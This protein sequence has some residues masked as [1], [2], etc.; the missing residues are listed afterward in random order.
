MKPG[1]LLE[2]CVYWTKLTESPIRW[3]LFART[4]RDLFSESPFHSRAEDRMAAQEE[5]EATMR[6]LGVSKLRTHR[7]ALPS[8]WACTP[9]PRKPGHIWKRT[10][11]VVVVACRRDYE[12][13][14]VKGFVCA[15]LRTGLIIFCTSQQDITESSL[16]S[17]ACC[18]EH[19]KWHQTSEWFSPSAAHRL[20]SIH[21]SV[22]GH[23]SPP[24]RPPAGKETII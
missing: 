3:M 9:N 5:R 7:F 11:N 15:S 23:P 2:L 22:Q 13:W 1:L 18:W 12:V 8:R 20:R 10:R 17:E 19:R 14:V 4:H 6:R 24:L 21:C 16:A